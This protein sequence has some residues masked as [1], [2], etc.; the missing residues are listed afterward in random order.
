MTILGQRPSRLPWYG[1]SRAA[2]TPEASRTPFPAPA[3]ELTRVLGRPC[4]WAPPAGWWTTPGSPPCCCATSS[5]CRAGAEAR[6]AFFSWRLRPG[7]APGPAPVRPGHAAGGQRLAPGGHA[8]APQG[9]LGPG[10]RGLGPADA[11]P[12][13]ALAVALQPAG[14]RPGSCPACC[15]PCAPA[16]MAAPPAPWPPGAATCS[17]CASGPN[18]RPGRDWVP[19]AGPAH[20]RPTSSGTPG[21][22]RSCMVWGAAGVARC[23]LPPRGSSSPR[24]RPR[25][26]SDGRPPSSSSTSRRPAPSGAS[27]TSCW[28]GRPWPVG[29][30]ILAGALGFT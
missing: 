17:C 3:D 4:R 20:H 19:G 23:G 13:A 11:P 5:S 25:R 14:A 7:P 12:R 6:E 9:R 22:P 28:A 30:L 2:S 26:P 29:A 16:G 24:S 18:P 10:R 21:R 8:A 15:C 27:T 1:L